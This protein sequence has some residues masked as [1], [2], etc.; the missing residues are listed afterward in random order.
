MV[1]AFCPRGSSPCPDE[2]AHVHRLS[3]QCSLHTVMSGVVAW[4]V[5]LRTLHPKT[6]SKYFFFHNFDHF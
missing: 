4:P 1:C 5:M 3:N 6:H 2:T